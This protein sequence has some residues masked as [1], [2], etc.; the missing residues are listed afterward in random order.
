M[1]GSAC[2]YGLNKK[3]TGTRDAELVILHALGSMGHVVHSNVSGP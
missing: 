1:L 2:T 3:R